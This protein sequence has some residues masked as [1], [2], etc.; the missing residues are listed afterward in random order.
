MTLSHLPQKYGIKINFQISKDAY[1]NLGAYLK[2]SSV[3]FCRG[4]VIKV[5]MR[6]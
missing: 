3:F 6:P 2:Y 1:F 5:E 4:K